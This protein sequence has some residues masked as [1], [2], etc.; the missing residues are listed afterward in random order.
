M[1]TFSDT[2]EKCRF[3]FEIQIAQLFKIFRKLFVSMR[4]WG[5]SLCYGVLGCW[6]INNW[7]QINWRI[8]WLM[9]KDHMLSCTARSDCINASQCSSILFK[10]FPLFALTFADWLSEFSSRFN[11]IRKTLCGL[12]LNEHSSPWQTEQSHGTAETSWLP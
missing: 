12:A 6:F 9:D 7:L 3:N 11:H 2:A 4:T 8:Q 10:L 1:L 5:E